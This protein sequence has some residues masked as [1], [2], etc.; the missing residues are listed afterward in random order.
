MKNI[1]LTLIFLLSLTIFACENNNESQEIAKEIDTSINKVEVID[2]YGTRR[3][4]TCKNIEANTTYTL[5]TFF[6]EEIEN[7][8][9][10]LKF[11]DVDDENNY[12]IAEEYQATSTALFLNV[13]KNGV[14][15][16]IDLTKFAFDWGNE[17]V[18]FSMELENKIRVEL[19]KL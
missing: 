1:K 14:E 11:I 15:T 13:I 4:T 17:Q 10:E 3:C 8:T 12:K 7:G 6:K 16:H 2:F 19:A 18:E 9:V 5:E